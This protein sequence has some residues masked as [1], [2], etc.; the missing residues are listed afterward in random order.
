MDAAPVKRGMTTSTMNENLSDG[1]SGVRSSYSESKASCPKHGGSSNIKPEK[2]LAINVK[3]ETNDEKANKSQKEITK[4]ASSI[5]GKYTKNQKSREG[6]INDET[7]L[8]A[9][10][11]ISAGIVELPKSEQSTSTN[12]TTDNSASIGYNTAP[13]SNALDDM[14]W[15]IAKSQATILKP[16]ESDNSTAKSAKSLS[17]NGSVK[18]A[19]TKICPVTWACYKSSTVNLALPFK[20]QSRKTTRHNS[21]YG[22]TDDKT[23]KR[24][25]KVTAST[26]TKTEAATLTLTSTRN[27]RDS[28]E[29]NHKFNLN[30]A[31]VKKVNA[32]PAYGKMVPI[33]PASTDNKSGTSAPAKITKPKICTTTSKSVASGNSYSAKVNIVFKVLKGSAATWTT[34]VTT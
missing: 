14:E 10:A 8:L 4:V 5:P 17:E 7:A 12:Q 26:C 13:S 9:S 20:R 30:T 2:T 22:D 33:T 32:I 23:S 29:T 1:G 27:G 25:D 19:S 6:C 28:L 24:P 11:G 3:L 16:T 21:S 34:A 31:T 18:L 15:A